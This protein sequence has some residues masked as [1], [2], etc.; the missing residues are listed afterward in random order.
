MP[1]LND[2]EEITFLDFEFN[3]PPGEQPQVLCMA[4]QDLRTG[5]L[6]RMWRDDLERCNR[7]PFRTDGR[8]LVVA[9]YASAEMNCFLALGWPR[10]ANLLDLY[11]EYSLATS[12]LTRP[13]GRTL[14]GALTA[15]GISGGV[16]Q[17]YKDEMRRLAQRGGPYTQQERS[18]LLDYCATDVTP[19]PALLRAMTP[20]IESPPTMPAA[21]HHKAL[22][23]ALLR[24]DYMKSI[25]EMEFRGIPID[26]A[27]LARLL[28]NWDKIERALIER[29]DRAFGVYRDG[30][31]SA[32]EFERLLV[33]RRMSWPRHPSGALMLDRDTFYDMSQTY[34]DLVPLYDLRV[35]LAQ[36]RAWDLSVG[37][38][39]RN[40]CL[41]APFG[42]K[43]GRNTP[44]TSNFIFGLS[45]WLRGL[46]RP[47]PGMALAYC[48]FE[49]QEFGEAAFFSGDKNMMDAYT[50]GDPYLAFAKQ[51]GAI[52]QEVTSKEEI[53]DTIYEAV[54]DNF[55]TC[56]LGTQYGMGVEA[57]ANRIG[58]SL[59]QS[60]ELLRYH[61][62][63]YP[64]LWKW[65]D[66][67]VSFAML[68][69]HLTATYGWRV[70]A[71]PETRPTALR[72]FQLQANGAEMLRWACVLCSERGLPICAPIHDALLVEDTLEN[73][74]ATVEA[75]KAAMVE[76]SEKVL[77]GFPLRVEAKVVRWP[78][79]Y[80][81][82]R[83][84]RMWKK[85][86]ALVDEVE[87]AESVA[88]GSMAH[89]P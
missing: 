64:D 46:I 79:R 38:D 72:N 58:G 26:T 36:M 18:A 5:R 6:V 3:Q 12:G 7:A 85:V 37:S 17:Q 44:S 53:K 75:V 54:R 25:G 16:S 87:A 20:V 61:H 59:S 82:K 28:S 27:M 31:F 84:A 40:R 22:G 35:T 4:A 52:P 49:Q 78:E 76:A 34:P 89:A 63:K 14:L 21:D 56:A 73:I 47:R 39:G 42:A 32:A 43:T 57:L 62:E 83:G 30:S 50:S 77:P 2:F 71:G 8:A 23:Q 33:A 13:H 69:G 86:W 41:L 88:L 9:Y 55:K 15:Y 24:G 45:T 1:H 51:A 65:S 74:A 29:E 68:Y 80:M 60:R 11:V 19:L 67:C 10:P 70:H 81:D 48:D 66:A